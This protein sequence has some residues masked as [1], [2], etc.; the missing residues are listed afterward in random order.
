VQV[1]SGDV[2][3]LDV[4]PPPLTL[5]SVQG[6]LI[7]A[8]DHGDLALNAS[9]IF[10]NKGHLIVGTEARP[11]QYRYTATI[12]LTGGRASPEIPIYG[13]KCIGTK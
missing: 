7:F 6:T 8:D 1:P 9:Y 12:T 4:S 13:A 10:I 3:V 2:V 5:V 11:F